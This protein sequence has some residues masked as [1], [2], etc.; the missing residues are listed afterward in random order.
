MGAMKEFEQAGRDLDALIAER[1]M[2]WRRCADPNH[3]PECDYWWTDATSASEPGGCTG[4]RFSTDI[5]DAWLVVEK[6]IKRGG[7]EIQ[8]DTDGH[9]VFF[10]WATAKAKTAPLAICLAALKAVGNPQDTPERGKT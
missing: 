1:V 8:G 4:R 9:W 7:F 10:R 3:G 5:E 6:M 2:G